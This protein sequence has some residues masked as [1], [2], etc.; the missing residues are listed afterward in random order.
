MDK[1]A[2]VS[3]LIGLWPRRADLAADMNSVLDGG[4]AISV[5]Q[6]HKWARNGSIPAR[7]HLAFLSS[8]T[9]RGFE[10]N[11]DLIVQIHGATTCQS[12]EDAA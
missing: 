10:V 4:V 3:D 11:A 12:Q 2:T 9:R 8:A 1:I 6:V 7:F 5:D